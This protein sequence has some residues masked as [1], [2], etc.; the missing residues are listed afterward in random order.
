MFDCPPSDPV[1]QLPIGVRLGKTEKAKIWPLNFNFYR[2]ADYR[3]LNSMKVAFKELVRPQIEGLPKY[4]TLRLVYTFFP[5]SAREIDT[6]NVCAVVDKF[7]CDALVELGR[8]PDDNYKHLVET[9]FRFGAI[10]RTHPRVDVTLSGNLQEQESMKISLDTA[11]CHA[12]L[13]QYVRGL[14]AVQ[15]GTRL[16]IDI[17]NARGEPGITADVNLIP[18]TQDSP[19]GKAIGAAG[20][21][22]ERLGGPV[23]QEPKKTKTKETPPEPIEPGPEDPDPIPFEANV[24]PVAEIQKPTNPLFG[25]SPAG[26]KGVDSDGSSGKPVGLSPSLEAKPTSAVKPLFDF[27]SAKG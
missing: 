9:V 22:T 20:K 15:P 18:E 12:A 11:D 8:L 16:Q 26:D 3:T 6:N 4:Q 14:I 5:G 25:G 23:M 10:D 13:D 17:K 27:P 19:V 7:F 1:L 21:L 2:N 24:E